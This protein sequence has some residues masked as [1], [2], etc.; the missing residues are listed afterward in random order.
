MRSTGRTPLPTQIQVEAARSVT[1][2]VAVLFRAFLIHRC[3]GAD[4]EHIVVTQQ[5]YVK[6]LR[7]AVPSSFAP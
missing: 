2:V 6:P 3:F 7:P 4:E 5:Q 1:D